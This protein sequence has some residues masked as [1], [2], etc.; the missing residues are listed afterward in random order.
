MMG[1]ESLEGGGELVGGDE[2]GVEGAEG[3]S[4]PSLAAQHKE[5]R[6]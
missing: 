6:G 1:A 5:G 4:L 2:V 3:L